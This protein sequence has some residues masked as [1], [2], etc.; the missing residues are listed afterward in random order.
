M[1]HYLRR[2]LKESFYAAENRPVRWAIDRV[3]R[4]SAA[5]RTAMIDYR[6][7]HEAIREPLQEELAKV[8]SFSSEFEIELYV[9]RFEADFARL[10]NRRYGV[11]THSGTAALQLALAALGIGAGDEVITVPYTYIATAL[12]ISNTGATPV[13]VDVEHETFNIDP[14]RISAA[15]TPRTKAIVPVHLYGQ[16]ANMPAILEVAAAHGLRVVEDACQAFGAELHGVSAG[17]AGDVGCFSFSSPK[18]LSGFGNGGAVVSNDRA[19]IEKIR[20]LRNPESNSPILHDSRRTPCYLDAL[21]VAFIRTKLP[22]IQTWTEQRR[23]RAAE[24][25]RALA[26]VDCELPVEIEGARHSYY[27]FALRMGRRDEVRRWMSRHGV[28]T[29][30][31]YSPC[32]HLTDVYARLGCGRG[33]FPR[34]EAAERDT[35]LLPLTPFLTDEEMERICAALR[36][37]GSVS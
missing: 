13:F 8:L 30:P 10:C 36:G 18:N 19:L 23:A 34:A 29:L 24:Y 2:R 9:R 12:A 15:I 14:A 25:R 37:F 1:L 4:S 7:T 16:M 32:L 3:L 26:P 33:A 21:Q 20:S 5:N 22:F 11:G 6:R 28:R 31:G 35:L 27:R 17:A